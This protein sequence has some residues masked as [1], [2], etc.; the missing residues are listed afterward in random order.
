MGNPVIRMY[1]KAGE[2]HVQLRTDALGNEIYPHDEVLDLDGV[3][4]NLEHITTDDLVDFLIGYQN[5]RKY[6]IKK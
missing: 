2:E 4:I 1:E 6:R 3:L 5:A